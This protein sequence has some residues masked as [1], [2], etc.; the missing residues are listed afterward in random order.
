MRYRRNALEKF[1]RSMEERYQQSLAQRY[2]PR[3][4]AAP[5]LS[6]H[7]SEAL[8][9]AR[10]FAE[11]L[12]KSLRIVDHEIGQLSQ[13]NRKQFE[14]MANASSAIYEGLKQFEREVS[15]YR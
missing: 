5:E 8:A 1:R 14:R 15:V 13:E 10:Y 11:E 7:A 9:N 4:T 12:W 6:R 3:K 2:K